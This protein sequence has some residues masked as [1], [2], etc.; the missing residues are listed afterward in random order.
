V[1]VA[2]NSPSSSFQTR[3]SAA[4]PSS[5]GTCDVTSSNGKFQARQPSNWPR[6][7]NS[8]ASNTSGVIG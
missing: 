7:G 5:I 2:T 3:F 6:A 1:V 8:L 4:N